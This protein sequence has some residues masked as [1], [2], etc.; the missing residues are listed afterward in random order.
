MYQCTSGAG[1]LSGYQNSQPLLYNQQQL[2]QP[3]SYSQPWSASQSHQAG[4]TLQD[5]SKRKSISAASPQAC[6]N[7]GGFN[8]WAQNCPEPRRAVPAGAVT[9]QYPNKR[10]R[11]TAPVITKYPVPPV[12]TNRAPYNQQSHV[13]Q[14]GFTFPPATQNLQQNA[15]TPTAMPA[16]SHQPQPWQQPE[17]AFNTLSRRQSQQWTAPGLSPS[18]VASNYQCTSPTS[19]TSSALQQNVVGSSNCVRQHSSAAVAT[20]NHA[21]A[22][23]PYQ[24]PWQGPFAKERDSLLSQQHGRNHR[25]QPEGSQQDLHDES[26]EE[27]WWEDLRTL[28]YSEDSC[29]SSHPANPV[30]EPL[31]STM[32]DQDFV[33]RLPIAASLPAGTPVSKYFRNLTVEDLLRN[34]SESISGAKDVGDPA[35]DMLTDDCEVISKD[36]LI[37]KRCQVFSVE[38][39]A[40][41][42]GEEPGELDCKKTAYSDEAQEAEDNIGYC[43]EGLPT[44]CQ[45]F[46]SEEERSA[47]EQEEKLAALGVTGFA[48]PVRTSIRRSTAPKPTSTQDTHT[49]ITFDANTRHDTYAPAEQRPDPFDGVSW[50]GYSRSGSPPPRQQALSLQTPPT[51]ACHDSCSNNNENR[52]RRLSSTVARNPLSNSP[53]N[54]QDSSCDAPGAGSPQSEPILSNT[55]RVGTNADKHAS[56]S[57]DHSGEGRSRKRSIGELSAEVEEGPKRQKEK[58]H[59]KEKRKAPKVAAAYNRRW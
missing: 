47:R 54:C 32:T 46:E 55:A 58:I 10:Q 39:D 57:S 30:A 2:K 43:A 6:Y 7:C 52:P 11:I 51:S 38:R 27:S 40:V 14:R 48:K 8:H 34:S 29:D 41:Y 56:P 19:S 18:I 37:A 28:D 12:A 42:R 15:G 1:S 49:T 17:W 45:S 36:E 20:S 53:T 21:F 9:S 16:K 22:N 23:G 35:F 13:Q 25:Q 4:T 24:K 50:E 31:P 44:P 33:T 5:I 59:Q 3:I 26:A